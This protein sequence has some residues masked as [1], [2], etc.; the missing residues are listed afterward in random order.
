MQPHAYLVNLSRGNLVDEDALEAALNEK[1]IAGA[2]LDVGRAR[3]SD[4][5]A[6]VSQD[7]P[8][9]WRRRISAD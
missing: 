4:A 7:A 1:R 6:A 8:T 5:L 2:A 9:C 3:R